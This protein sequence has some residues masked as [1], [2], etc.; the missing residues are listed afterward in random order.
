M[1]TVQLSKGMQKITHKL[2]KKK[3]RLF[4]SLAYEVTMY[5]YNVI[6]QFLIYQVLY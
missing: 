2:K 4:N 6:E 3:S 1:K 5:F